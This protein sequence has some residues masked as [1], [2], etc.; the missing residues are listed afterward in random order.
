M[1]GDC[2]STKLYK[3]GIGAAY[4]TAK[5]AATTAI[6][7][8]ISA[9]DF[10][11]YYW[12]SCQTINIDNFIGKIIFSVTQQIQKRQ[13]VKHGVLRMVV[14]E[15]NK[16]GNRRHMSTVL[17]DTFTGSAPYR[18]IFLRTL[19]P[20]FLTSLMWET[21]GVILSPNKNRM[22][23]ENVVNTNALG[24]V[25][26]EGETIIS[27][28]ET[29]DC[30]YVIQSGKVVVVQVEADKEVHLAELGEGDFFGEMALFEREVRSTSMRAQ[31]DVRV[32]A[33]D[34]KTLLRRIQ[35]DP[36]MAFR[37][38]Q[39]MTSRIRELDAELSQLKTVDS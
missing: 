18:D 35:E 10:K 33:I 37:M 38:L 28:G 5:A 26:Q 7:Q 1:V 2:A 32:L 34:K 13:Y 9:E 12:P 15:G 22:I 11:Q 24:K 21:A 23:E 19:N 27:Q 31:G 17:W 16:E 30:M 39:K 36:S 20:L 8:G 29:G 4:V 25:Y 3:N 14:K 6:L